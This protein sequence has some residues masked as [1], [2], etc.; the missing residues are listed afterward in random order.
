[1]GNV[2]VPPNMTPEVQQRVRGFFLAIAGD[3]DA[4]TITAEQVRH[5]AD[6]LLGYHRDGR[7]DMIEAH[8]LLTVARH[9][10]LPETHVAAL[11]GTLIEGTALAIPAAPQAPGALRF[12]RYIELSRLRTDDREQNGAAELGVFSDPRG[13]RMALTLGNQ[14]L[15][16]RFARA[17]E[18]LARQP[19]LRLN[20]S[21]REA[22]ARRM[23]EIQLVE[24]E[25]PALDPH[26]PDW[27]HF[28]ADHVPTEGTPADE[29]ELLDLGSFTHS[30]IEDGV[31]TEAQTLP[32][33]TS[34]A[35]RYC[36]TASGT[37]DVSYDPR[38]IDAPTE[39]FRPMS[40]RE[41]ETFLGSRMIAPIEPDLRVR[42]LAAVRSFLA[43]TAE[44]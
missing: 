18:D 4:Q 38:G 20:A 10:G 30:H 12:P 15:E 22:I 23:T 5:A 25:G 13:N 35:I 6:G 40:R 11:R 42:N 29:R 21:E 36:F 31:T 17:G 34:V 2:Q 28:T 16:A 44:L 19:A 26:A 7:V 1:M 24:T 3:A 43:A 14:G 37:I 41:L 27:D 33:G 32:D 39:S 9:S 8:A